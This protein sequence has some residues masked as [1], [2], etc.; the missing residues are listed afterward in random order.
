MCGG[1]DS[2]HCAR[3]CIS[4]LSPRVRGNQSTPYHP[5]R[6]SG[7]IPACAGEPHRRSRTL[8]K[9]RV[10]PRVCGGT[11]FGLN[12][13]VPNTASTMGLSPRVR[14][15]LRPGQ[16]LRQRLGS[17][18]ACAGEP[19]TRPPYGLLL[20]VYPRVC[21]GT[22]VM[23]LLLCHG[24]AGLSPRVRG[25]RTFDNR[26]CRVFVRGNRSGTSRPAAPWVY[27]RVCGGSLAEP[28]GLKDL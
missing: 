20:T 5:S 17:I 7:S 25:N 2:S 24:H 22:F 12:R 8:L 23:G 6:Y 13:P 18:P 14:G 10:Y 27:P 19:N 9:K 21:G 3:Y 11:P 1:T 15:N 16:S 26:A 28:I 4:G